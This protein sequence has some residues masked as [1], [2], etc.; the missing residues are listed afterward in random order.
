[1]EAQEINNSNPPEIMVFSGK[2]DEWESYQESLFQIFKT[3]ILEVAITFQGLPVKARLSPPYKNKP[4]AFWHLISEGE[5]ENERVPDLRRCERVPWICWVIEN[6]E[7]HPDVS[8]WENTR[9]TET[10]VVILF[11]KE[12]YVVILAKRKGYFLLKSA[13]IPQKKRF[14]TLLRERADFRK[15]RP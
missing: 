15:K 7:K 12:K 4:F 13:Y 14:E 9:G 2:G 11:E 5:K 6:C 8:C 1:M 3:K 10:H